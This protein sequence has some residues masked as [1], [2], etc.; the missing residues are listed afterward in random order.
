MDA[1][2]RYVFAADGYRVLRGFSVVL[3]GLDRPPSACDCDV[4]WW[5]SDVGQIYIDCSC[6]PFL[7]RI[8]ILPSADG[9]QAYWGA[10]CGRWIEVDAFFTER[11]WAGGNMVWKVHGQSCVLLVC[12]GTQMRI[13]SVCCRIGWLW[14]GRCFTW[15]LNGPAEFGKSRF[16]NI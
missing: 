16:R 2:A 9:T 4:P 10:K 15:F 1:S 13:D 7:A 5:F 14:A 6:N 12:D 3:A 11:S 8:G